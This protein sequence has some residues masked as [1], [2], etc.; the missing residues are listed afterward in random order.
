MYFTGLGDLPTSLPMEVVGGLKI[1]VQRNSYLLIGGG[2]LMMFMATT[3]EVLGVAC[4]V[5]AVAIQYIRRGP[6]DPAPGTRP[7]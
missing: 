1:F 6:D 4:I 7:A 2:G 5:A 3:T